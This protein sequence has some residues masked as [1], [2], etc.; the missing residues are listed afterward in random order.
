MRFGVVCTQFNDDY[1]GVE[2]PCLG[3]Q[4]FLHIRLVS[5]VEQRAGTDAEVLY[6]IILAEHY[7]QYC[8]IAF[9]RTVFQAVAVCDAV[10]YT[11]NPRR[12]FPFCCRRQNQNDEKK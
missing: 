11:C 4:L 8:G 10:A 7:P 6:R 3:K 5:L 2:R 9:F 1:V 12:S